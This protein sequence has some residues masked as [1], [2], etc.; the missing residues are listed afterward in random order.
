MKFIADVSGTQITASDRVLCPLTDAALIIDID[1]GC[2]GSCL[3]TV[4]ASTDTL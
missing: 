2:D 4:M 1:F 3:A